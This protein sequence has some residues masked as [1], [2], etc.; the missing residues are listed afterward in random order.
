M[1][2]FEVI[3]LRTPFLGESYGI[4]AQELLDGTW[5]SVALI[6]DISKDK[7]FAVS[8]AAKC[9]RGQLSPMQLL[10]V[11]MDALC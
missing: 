7:A 11:V 5:H 9:A 6:P 4:L 2:R 1:Y 3:E 10:D 8:L